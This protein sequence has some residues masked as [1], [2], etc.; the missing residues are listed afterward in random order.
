[1]TV[2]EIGTCRGNAAGLSYMSCTG[3]LPTTNIED[4]MDPPRPRYDVAIS[5]LSQDEPIATALHDRLTAGCSGR[6]P[7]CPGPPAQI[8]TCGFPASG[9]YRRSDVIAVLDAAD[10]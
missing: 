1:M 4:C 5:F 10:P 7:G 2:K 8:P 3:M 9:S 6:E